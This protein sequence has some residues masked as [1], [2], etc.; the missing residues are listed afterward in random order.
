MLDRIIE[1]KIIA[2]VRGIYGDDCLKLADALRAGGIELIEVTFDQSRPDLHDRTAETIRRLAG[3]FT[4]SM[5]VGA[6][7]VTSTELVG[8]AAD[9][10]AR[11][12]IS[13]DTNPAVIVETKR[14]GLIS[15]PGAFTPTEILAAHNCGADFVKVFP[16]GSL[17]AAYIKAV[18]APLNN[19]RLMAVGG[20]SSANAG[21]FI[22][23]GACGIG[24]GGNLVDKKK[25]AAGKFDELTLEARRLCESVREALD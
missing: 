14:R 19:V 25:I 11:F 7:T 13:P 21:E 15:I 2:I 5:G 22:R 16:A 3:E 23:A 12:M 9:A 20:V 17:G 4:D 6:G 1:K 8:I 18:R 24:V 10:G